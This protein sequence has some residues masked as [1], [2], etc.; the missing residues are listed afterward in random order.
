MAT[1]Y[2]QHKFDL[3]ELRALGILREVN[4]VFFH[5]LG[6]ALAVECDRDTEAPHAICLLETTDP[7][8]YAFGE[9]DR[10]K[11]ARFKEWAAGR[12]PER[13]AA[14]GYTVQPLD[15]VAR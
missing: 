15:E 14:L 13:Q 5:P 10:D 1:K 12:A 4:R 8:G 7:E 2:T 6:L 9:L 11:V 3:N